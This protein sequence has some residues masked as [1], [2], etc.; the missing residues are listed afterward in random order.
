VFFDPFSRTFH[1]RTTEGEERLWTVGV[2]G[3][4]S[5][6]IVVHTVKE[7]HGEE[8]IRIISA[9]KATHHERHCYEEA[10]F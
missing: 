1:E 4:L 3:N 10:Q 9:R 5:T 7:E 8:I 2:T 6:V